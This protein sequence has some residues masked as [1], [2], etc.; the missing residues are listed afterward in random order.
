MK[1]IAYN[2]NLEIEKK[3]SGKPKLKEHAQI[4]VDQ[5]CAC[6]IYLKFATESCVIC[7]NYNR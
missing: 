3:L 1:E 2:C 4:L 6:S 5:M 7:S